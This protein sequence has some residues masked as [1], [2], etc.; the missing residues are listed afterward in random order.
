[1]IDTGGL[2]GLPLTFYGHF[3]GFSS[4]PVVCLNLARWLISQGV[5]LRV[6]NLR[7]DPVPPWLYSYRVR[8]DVQSAVWNRAA[9]AAISTRPADP[10]DPPDRPD[11]IGMLFGFPDWLPALPR[12]PVMIGYHVGDVD[13]VPWKWKG[14]IE[15]H[16]TRVATP[17][18]WCKRLIDELE[19]SGRNGPI[20]TSVVHHGID[21]EVFRPGDATRSAGNGTSTKR[22]LVSL[23]HFCSSPSA[24]RKGTVELLRATTSLLDRDFGDHGRHWVQLSAAVHPATLQSL[25]SW[26]GEFSGGSIGIVE[27]TPSTHS[28]TVKTMRRCDVLVQP[29]RA[30]GFGLMPLEAVACGTPVVLLGQ[31]GDADYLVDLGDAAVR[32]ASRG[33][34]TCS[35]GEAP[36]ID[37]DSLETAIGIAVRD[38][39]AL[40]WHALRSSECV[41][42][43]WSW[44][45]VLRK[46][47]V[48]VL[49]A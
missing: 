7:T 6:C 8:Q 45:A 46:E 25:G 49:L 36:I 33:M 14:L 35:G 16:C 23:R 28:R 5:D 12:H 9:G 24:E 21:P 44:D 38:A 27:D 13:P 4:Y 3:S 37:Q 41:R 20:S 34:G 43:R 30:E 11:A 15:Q 1:M 29:S 17:S 22:A 26:A 19:L 40:R 48:P 42:E 10:P 47:L 39:E 32:V 2:R 31:T 18:A